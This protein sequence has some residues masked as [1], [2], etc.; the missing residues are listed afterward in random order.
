M[1]RRDSWVPSSPK[2]LHSTEPSYHANSFAG[3]IRQ[4]IIG[5]RSLEFR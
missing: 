5:G 4:L 2:E 1:D 3:A